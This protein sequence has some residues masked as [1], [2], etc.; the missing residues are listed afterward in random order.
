PSDAIQADRSVAS[1]LWRPAWSEADGH[2]EAG[3]HHAVFGA[4][5]ERRDVPVAVVTD[6]GTDLQL[7]REVV[8]EPDGVA[9]VGTREGRALAVLVPPPLVA[10]RDEAS[11]PEAE[12]GVVGRPGGQGRAGEVPPAA[13][14]AAQGSR[15][16]GGGGTIGAGRC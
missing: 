8:G 15:R 5:V 13:A 4:Q 7:R 1:P 6:L 14:A 16:G 12:H 3:Q 2:V 11:L 10:D 9:A